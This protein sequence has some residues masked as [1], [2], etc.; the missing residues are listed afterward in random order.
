MRP[1]CLSCVKKHVAQAMILFTEAANGYPLH[2]WW[3]LGHLAEA[4]A[5]CVHDFPQ[6]AETIRKFR[7]AYE[8]GENKLTLDELLEGIIVVEENEVKT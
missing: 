5:E 3:A 1:S 6:L 2:F 8:N 4:E 7:L